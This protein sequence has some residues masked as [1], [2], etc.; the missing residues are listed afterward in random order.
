LG[1]GFSTEEFLIEEYGEDD[2][3]TVRFNFIVPEIEPG[4]YST[5]L[6]VYYNGKKITD[7]LALNIIEPGFSAET[8]TETES[9][10][11]DSSLVYEESEN[12]RLDESKESLIVPYNYKPVKERKTTSI[13]F[14]QP[15]ELQD[16]IVRT[17]LWILNAVLIIGILF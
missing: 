9:E 7:S 4:E 13:S 11:A 14:K 15:E 10:E 17:V 1:V 5:A 8:S 12:V 3:E 16:P 2:G 6:E